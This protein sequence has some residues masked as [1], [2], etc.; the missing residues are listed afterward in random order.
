MPI[1]Y[2]KLSK[3]SQ[4]AIS[5]KNRNIIIFMY[6]DVEFF[7]S[8]FICSICCHGWMHHLAKV[9]ITCLIRLLVSFHYTQLLGSIFSSFYAAFAISKPSDEMLSWKAIPLWIAD[10]S[11][12]T[13]DFCQR[14]YSL[15][16][17][18]AFDV[19]VCSM[20]A[21]VRVH[22]LSSEASCMHNLVES[23]HILV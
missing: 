7:K 22:Q 10:L 21:K 12:N 6:V 16:L 5:K 23:Q 14:G 18:F 1:Y 3:F 11:C 19:T 17:E 9:P 2:S 4:N 8:N 13:T 15:V 20:Y